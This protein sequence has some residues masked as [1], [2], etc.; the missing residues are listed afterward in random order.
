[1]KICVICGCFLIDKIKKP[2]DLG[3]LINCILFT[4]LYNTSLLMLNS[5]N[6]NRDN[7]DI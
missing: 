1:M 2:P 6:V 5:N 3:G 4:Y 7:N